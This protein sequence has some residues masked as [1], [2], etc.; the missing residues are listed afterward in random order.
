[1]EG[2]MALAAVAMAAAAGNVIGLVWTGDFP[3][4]AIILAVSLAA[5]SFA[6]GAMSRQESA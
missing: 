6:F 2:E 3:P 4:T 1:M 5:A